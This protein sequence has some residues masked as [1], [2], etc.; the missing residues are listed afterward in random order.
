MCTM[1]QIVEI[2]FRDSIWRSNLKIEF[3]QWIAKSITQYYVN[4]IFH[5][6]KLYN[7]QKLPPNTQIC[8]CLYLLSFE[9]GRCIVKNITHHCHWLSLNVQMFVPI[10]K[11]IQICTFCGFIESVLPLAGPSH[12]LVCVQPNY[13]GKCNTVIGC[14]AYSQYICCEPYFRYPTSDRLLWILYVG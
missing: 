3:I 5:L 6:E 7:K 12:Q 9:A 10:T 13:S 2:Q 4:F 1:S 11:N 8:V 14:T